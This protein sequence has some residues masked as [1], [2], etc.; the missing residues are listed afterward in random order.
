MRIGIFDSGV[1]GMSV[2]RSIQ[3]HSA[4]SKADY[5]YCLDQANFPYGTKDET[6]VVE[7]ATDVCERFVKAA[8]LDILVIACGTASTVTLPAVRS[9]VGCAVVG[10][11]PAVKPAAASSLTKH[12][13]V[14]A[15]KATVQRPYLQGLIDEFAKGCV[16]TTLGSSF[17]VE[18]AEQKM[19]GQGLDARLLQSEIAPLFKD[20]TQPVDAVV[21]GCTHFPL[22][23]DE[24]A[25]AAPWPVRWLDSGE[26]VSRRV[27][28]LAESIGEGVASDTGDGCGYTTGDV[29]QLWLQGVPPLVA[30]LGLLN[31]KPL[32][33]SKPGGL[34]F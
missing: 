21:L 6:F 17:L 4:L 12:I 13:G 25:A 34:H 10:V 5:F 7:V 11:V 3:Q 29:S 26:A 19:R 27:E 15:T 23:V 18:W 32:A 14:L 30:N 28:S 9:R 2:L 24:L 22:L 1:G 16:V 8:R 33:L 31:W 20:R